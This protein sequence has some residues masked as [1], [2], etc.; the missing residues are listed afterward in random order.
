MLI[1]KLIPT[2]QN[3]GFQAADGVST[4][5]VGTGRLGFRPERARRKGTSGFS[6]GGLHWYVLAICTIR[7][8]N[9]VK[10]KNLS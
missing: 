8:N 6:P 5:P 1:C 4:F 2:L 3:R 10:G 7:L 9:I